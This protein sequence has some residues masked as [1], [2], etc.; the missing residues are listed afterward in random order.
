MEEYCIQDNEDALIETDYEVSEI[1]DASEDSHDIQVVDFETFR[2]QQQQLTKEEVSP[3]K[4]SLNSSTKYHN[5][6]KYSFVWEYFRPIEGSTQF[7]C[8]L[9]Q[10][11]VGSQTSNLA[12]HLSSSHNILRQKEV[13]LRT[14]LKFLSNF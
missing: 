4:L 7:Q 13:S 5:K 10:S 2:R 1:F 3:T 11:C 14:R 9:C 6:R 8:L 12:R